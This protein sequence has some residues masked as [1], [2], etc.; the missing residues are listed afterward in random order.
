M[1]RDELRFRESCLLGSY[2]G[3]TAAIKLA[4]QNGLPLNW[5]YFGSRMIELHEKYDQLQTEVQK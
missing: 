1:S 2:L 4:L 5:E 3:L